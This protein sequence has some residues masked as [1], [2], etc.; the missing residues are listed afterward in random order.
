M[1]RFRV[2]IAFSGAVAKP[3][4]DQ[5]ECEDVFEIF[6]D[7]ERIALCDGA[8]ESS[9]S[10]T[11]ARI[12]AVAFGSLDLFASDFAREARRWFERCQREWGVWEQQVL[13]RPLQWFARAKLTHGAAATF[14]GIV[15]DR[16]LG[17]ADE[18][19]FRVVACGDTCLFLVRGGEI[20]RLRLAFPLVAFD[21]FGSMP[22]LIATSTPMERVIAS[23]RT[24]SGSLAPGDA[25]YMATDALSQW[26]HAELEQGRAPWATL[27]TIADESDLARFVSDEIGAGRLREDDVALIRI[28]YDDAGGQN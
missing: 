18:R 11:W 6:G 28:R 12:L 17:D 26:I 25:I 15:I 22:P 16:A 20:A 7:G 21:E 14:L 23:L 24:S 13:E 4:N 19:S 2:E 27:D 9:Y 3:G 1:S 8:T 5:A 10:A